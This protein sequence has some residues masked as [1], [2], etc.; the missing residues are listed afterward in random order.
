MRLIGA[1]AANRGG[2]HKTRLTRTD[3]PVRAVPIALS[4]FPKKAA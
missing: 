3:F 1:F 2:G 4:G